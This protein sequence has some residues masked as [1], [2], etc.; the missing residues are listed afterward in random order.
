MDYM[1][2]ARQQRRAQQGEVTIVLPVEGTRRRAV[3]PT[4]RK[5]RAPDLLQGLSDNAIYDFQRILENILSLR[6]R[7]NMQIIGMTS[8]HAHEGTSTIIAVLSLL[9]AVRQSSHLGIRNGAGGDDPL[10]RAG[11]NPPL[12]NVLLIDT[13][14]KHPILHSLFDVDF[15]PGL[16][17]Y[18]ESRMN[19]R[20]CIR[21]IAHSR[22][23]LLPAGH[24]T[25]QPLY[26]L[27]FDVLNDLLERIKPHL[28]LIFLDI[29]PLLEYA[30]GIT[31]S[32]LCD[33]IILNV[34]SAATRWESVQEAKSLAEKANVKIIGT[35]LNKR[36]SYVPNWVSRCL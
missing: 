26:Y 28:Y 8:A 4:R 3:A 33:G 2:D 20:T 15:Q 10:Q 25:D 18:L 19:L 9:A 5:Q 22:L 24:R 1:I 11:V 12:Q 7:N 23:R 21:N 29:P 6:Q 14:M 31:L 17:D 13:Q 36:K 27:F 16:S 34:K 32:K 30:E 35:I